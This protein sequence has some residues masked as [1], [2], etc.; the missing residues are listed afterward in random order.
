MKITGKV[1][2][3]RY[4]LNFQHVLY[5][6]TG[7]W[8]HILQEFPGALL[9]A[10]GYLE[11]DH[12]NQYDAFIDHGKMQGVVQNL[13]TNMLTVR[14]GIALHMGYVLFSEALLLPDEEDGGGLVLEGARFRINVNA[15]E[16][17]ASARRRSIKRWG[18]DC[19]VCGFN[20]ERA[21]GEL[22][23]NFT[24]V[25]H[26]VP[27]STAGVEYELDPEK[28]LRPVCANCHAMLHQ[29]SPPLLIEELRLFLS[30]KLDHDNSG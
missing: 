3:K 15:Y 11:F 10:D 4:L 14:G 5:S 20:F 9:D 26:L 6:V 21:Y 19:A 28:D 29:K 18:L 16:R 12:K 30:E 23:A 13:A 17:S 1:L 25:H 24:H 2:S 7:D 27:V 22:G 8:Y